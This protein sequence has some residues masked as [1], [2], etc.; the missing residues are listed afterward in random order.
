MEIY[1]S[2]C[3]SLK[4]LYFWMFLRGAKSYPLV[5]RDEM[6]QAGTKKVY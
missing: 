2:L 5:K 4:I 3:L 1:L 6:E